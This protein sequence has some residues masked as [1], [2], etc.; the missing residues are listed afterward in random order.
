MENEKKSKI[1]PF[2][3][4]AVAITISCSIFLVARFSS[5][6]SQGTETKI[7]A[8]VKDEDSMTVSAVA[9]DI[10]E[11]VEEVV[12]VEEPVNRYAEEYAD[13]MVDNCY[14]A[15]DYYLDL[16]F[17]LPDS[18]GKGYGICRADDDWAIFTYKIKPNGVLAVDFLA[19]AYTFL[20]ADD[21]A[22]LYPDLP[23]DYCSDENY[24]YTREGNVCY[25]Y[26]GKVFREAEVTFYGRSLEYYNRVAAKS[27]YCDKK[28]LP[29]SYNVAMEILRVCKDKAIELE[30]ELE[31]ELANL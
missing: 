18:N 16:Y 31:N 5:N 25:K 1:I 10:K 15:R 23:A 29:E 4:P 27:A 8:D 26:T 30:N 11:P 2:V 7:V 28:Y 24:G 12:E 3:I 20:R 22:G 17:D 9:E 19:G 13:Y 21:L 14:E 6:P